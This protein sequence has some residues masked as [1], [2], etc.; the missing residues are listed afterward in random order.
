M[1]EKMS[2]NIQKINKY[3]NVILPVVLIFIDYLAIVCAESLAFNFS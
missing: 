3:T 1:G 2:E